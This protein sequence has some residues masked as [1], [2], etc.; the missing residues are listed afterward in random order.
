MKPYPLKAIFFTFLI[1]ILFTSCNENEA[2]KENNTDKQKANETKTESVVSLTDTPKIFENIYT[3]KGYVESR[4][5][6]SEILTLIGAASTAK[7]TLLLKNVTQTQD[8]YTGYEKACDD[9][10]NGAFHFIIGQ[11]QNEL[12]E[13]Y[14]FFE[15]V[16][17]LQG[18]DL[19]IYTVEKVFVLAKDE[20]LRLT[21]RYANFDSETGNYYS[22]P[23]L[24]T[25]TVEVWRDFEFGTTA[26][27]N[28]RFY[29]TE[30]QANALPES[31]CE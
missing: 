5:E 1:L 3:K 7:E 25:E 19:F 14:G 22:D 15:P 20:K 8:G 4:A 28:G 13:P 27:F 2:S 26:E 29:L 12:I 11:D 21:I 16:M 18:Q 9:D 17:G 24:H 6:M 23:D 31:D 10:Y 30:K